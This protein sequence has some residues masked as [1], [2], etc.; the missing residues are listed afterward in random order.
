MISF[1]FLIDAGRAAVDELDQLADQVVVLSDTR[2]KPLRKGAVAAGSVAV[3]EAEAPVNGRSAA[4]VNGKTTVIEQLDGF[5]DHLVFLHQQHVTPVLD[6]TVEATGQTVDEVRETLHQKASEIDERYQRFMRDRFDPLFGRSRSEQLD[7]MAS[8]GV[9]I[10]PR[11]RWLNRRIAFSTA[12]LG[13]VI[14]GTTVFPPSLV[15]TIPL[16][17]SLMFPIYGIAVRAL[18]ERKVNYHV[19]SAVNVTGIWL[20]G[21]YAPATLSALLYYLGE[22]LLVITQDR[23]HKGLI[24]VFSKQ[25]LSVWL[26][27]DDDEI[28]VPFDQILPGDVIVVGAG[29]FM[30]VDGEVL[31]GV[32]SIDQQMLTGEAQPIEKTV[33]SLV[34]ASTV[35]LSGK[36]HVRVDK[37]GR[38]TVAANIGEVL[39]RTASYQASLQS[40]GTMLAHACAPPTLALGGLA[41]AVFGGESA[42]AVLNSSFGVNVRITAPIAMLNLLNIA[43]R[44]AILVKD[45]R[46]LELLHDVDTVVFDKTGTLTTGEPSVAAIRGLNGLGENELL[47]LAAAAEHRQSHPIARAIVAEA[48]ARGLSLPQIEDAHYELGYGIKVTIGEKLVRVG[49]D[50]FMGLEGIEVPPEVQARQEASHQHGHSMVLV[51][52]DGQLAGTIELQPTIRPEAAS[53]I[54]ALHARGLQVSIISGDQEEPTRRLAEQLGLDRYFANVLPEGKADLVEQLQA[55]GRAV[56]FV[57]DGINDSIALKKANVSVSLRGATTVATDTAQVVLMDQSLE[58]LTKLF[59]LAEEMDKVLKAGFVV[60]VVPGVINIAGVFLLHWGLYQAILFA[61]IGLLASLGVGA[62]PLLKHRNELRATDGAQKAPLP[63][64]P[65]GPHA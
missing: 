7:E 33:G 45:G 46:S 23:S 15:V 48:A 22:K 44:N 65:S 61:P 29:Q 59:E 28:E 50:R 25:P 26:L 47:T 12:T 58:K 11:E 43:S 20:G 62:Y 54:R 18:K 30:P 6:R 3:A 53:V 34:Y 55:E 49:S 1:R 57:G 21:F 51:A 37:A 19:L 41:W 63:P 32:A 8:E 60:G 42:L 9:T 35:V 4:P 10:S 52:V 31:E 40:K 39:N 2:L 24:Q 17:F 13:A 27:V 64:E 16:A 14:V 56:C 38:D 36:V 5:A